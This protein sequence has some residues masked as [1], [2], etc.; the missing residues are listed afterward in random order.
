MV[1]YG[2]YGRLWP[3]CGLPLNM[4]QTTRYRPARFVHNEHKVVNVPPVADSLA[5][6]VRINGGFLHGLTRTGHYSWFTPT[7]SRCPD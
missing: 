3:F 7:S 4:S 6:T 2:Q 5:N 1:E